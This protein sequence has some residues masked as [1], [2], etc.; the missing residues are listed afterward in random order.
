MGEEGLCFENTYEPLDVE[1]YKAQ[2]GL[3]QYL[4]AS[5]IMGGC[6]MAWHW[7]LS[8]TNYTVN[9]SSNI[10]ICIHDIRFSK[11][12]IKHLSMEEMFVSSADLVSAWPL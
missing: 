11:Y 5:R 10:C 2:R 8:G 7:S 1:I 12:P 3:E 6:V 9:S 4:E